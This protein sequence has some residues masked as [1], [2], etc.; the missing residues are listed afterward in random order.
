MNDYSRSQDTK[1]LN[2]NWP[3]DI[4]HGIQQKLGQGI[5]PLYPASVPPTK[6]VNTS[7]T[8]ISKARQLSLNDD[9]SSSL[10]N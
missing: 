8:K 3:K 5:S 1:D 9:L 2:P 7:S 4:T 6:L 10:N